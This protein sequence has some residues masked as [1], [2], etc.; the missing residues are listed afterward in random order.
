MNRDIISS[1]RCPQ[2]REPVSLEGGESD[3]VQSG[4]L[5]CPCGRT[6]PI[7]NSIPRFVKPAASRTAESFGMQWTTF[8]V[9]RDTEDV[10]VFRAKT[11]LSPDE[12]SGKRVLDA[13]CGGGRYA[14]IAAR[15]GAEVY[16]VDLSQAVERAA[17]LLRE[18]P[19]AHVIQADLG[20]LPFPNGFF[21][22]VYSIGVLHHTPN[23]RAAMRAVLRHL[24]PGGTLSIW[25]Y[26]KWRPALERVNRIERALTTRLPLPRMMQLA[27]ALEPLGAAKLRLQRSPSAIVRKLGVVLN[28]LTIGVSMHPVQQQRI[29]DTFDW[30]TPEYQWHHTDGEV[31]TWFEE[32]AFVEIANLS[33]NPGYFFHPGQGQGVNFKGRLGGPE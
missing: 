9:A 24:A 16:A 26:K 13:G 33:D 32:D 10:A 4:A 31:R 27:R 14:R 23:T 18:F 22:A 15:Y 8:D 21:D 12:I 19:N 30:Y 1:L 11:G 2:C 17:E 5:A 28:A 3:D 29:C 7:V 6:Y 25:L 20:K